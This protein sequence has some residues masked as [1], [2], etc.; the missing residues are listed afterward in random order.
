MFVQL[1]GHPLCMSWHPAPCGSFECYMYYRI[2]REGACCLVVCEGTSVAFVSF[3]GTEC[4][5]RSNFYCAFCGDW[6]L[7]V[8]LGLVG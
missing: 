6:D 1:V 7:T 4:R 3:V 5:E 8:I 2:S